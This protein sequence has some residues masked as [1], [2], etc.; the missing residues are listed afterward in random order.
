MMLNCQYIDTEYLISLCQLNREIFGNVGKFIYLGSCIKY[1][2]PTI[3]IAEVELRID[4]T[5]N[6]LYRYGKKFLIKR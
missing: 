4:C 5:E 2:Q 3:N 1:D 6:T